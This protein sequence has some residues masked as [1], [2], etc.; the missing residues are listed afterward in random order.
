MIHRPR[1][2]PQCH[3]MI[4][5][6]PASA[7]SRQ[8]GSAADQLRLAVTAYLARFKGSSRAVLLA[9]PRRDWAIPLAAS[10]LKVG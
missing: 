1:G 10:W 8:T 3:D 5:T 4:S 7:P 9:F 6:E 2:P